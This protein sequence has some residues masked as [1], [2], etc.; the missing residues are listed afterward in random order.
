MTRAA[1]GQRRKL[2][3]NS[4]KNLY[5]KDKVFQVLEQLGFSEKT[6]PETIFLEE[7]LKIFHLLKD[8]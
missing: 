7:Y 4:L 8:I 5:P 1:F 2:L 3:A 6:R